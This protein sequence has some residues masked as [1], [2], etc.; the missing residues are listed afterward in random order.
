MQTNKINP[1]NVHIRYQETFVG[2]VIE[3]EKNKNKVRC[4]IVI[5]I[6]QSKM[7]V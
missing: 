1:T 2:S 4:F 5:K 7:A 6:Y 3:R